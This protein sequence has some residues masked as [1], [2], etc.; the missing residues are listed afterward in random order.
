MKLLSALILNG[1]VI[2]ANAQDVVL[3]DAERDQYVKLAM[4]TAECSGYMTGFV[5]LATDVEE[6]NDANEMG[7][8]RAKIEDCFN[9]Y[10]PL[11][12]SVVES[13]LARIYAN[14]Q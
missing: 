9:D 3:T 7:M 5:D 6:V 11:V 13:E 10:Q 2:T 12:V 14:P 1:L 4:A 8:V